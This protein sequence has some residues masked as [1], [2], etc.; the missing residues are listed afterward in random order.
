MKKYLVMILLFSCSE[1][2]LKNLAQIETIESPQGKA[3]LNFCTLPPTFINQKVKLI[4]AIDVSGSNKVEHTTPDGSRRQPTDPDRS[5]RYDSLISWLNSRP[6]NDDEL[7]SLVEFGNNEAQLSSMIQN[8]PTAPFIKTSFEFRNIVETQRSTSQDEG[9]TPYLTLFQTIE[10]MIRT[11]ARNAIDESIRNQT[12]LEVSRYVII[13]LSDGQPSD[14][15]FPYST[16]KTKVSEEIMKLPE[17]LEIGAAIES[18][19]INTGYY[20]RDIDIDELRELL[21]SIAELGNGDFYPFNINSRSI[22]YNQLTRVFFKRVATTFQ[23]VIVENVNTIWDLR[24]K[25][26]LSDQDND[27]LS[28][29]LEISLGSNPRMADSDKNGVSDGAEMIAGAEGLPCKDPTCDPRLAF[30]FQGCFDVDDPTKLKDKDEDLI[31]TCE[32]ELYDTSDDT[33]ESGGAD[34]PDYL[35]LKFG[36][37]VTKS[38][39]PSNPSPPTATVDSDFDGVNNAEEIRAGTSP[40]IDNNSIEGLKRINYKIKLENYI[41]GTQQ[42]CFKIEATDIDVLSASDKVRFYV[43]EN[44]KNQTG[45]QFLRIFEKKMVGGL[46][47]LT[48]D[49]EIEPKRPRH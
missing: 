31:P 37:P 49:D 25:K 17:A 35:L 42:A 14:D 38:D 18:I 40:L 7:Y 44:E 24:E 1:S 36:L 28:D 20:Y 4:F 47:E 30:N 16:I 48:E 43:I 34:I 9:N 11:D 2:P 5:A 32:E 39:D 3:I 19:N 8:S 26:L 29:S 6:E 46:A 33:W 45:R 12:P 10:T 23:D 27:F 13:K 22:D 15:S 21:S 41:T